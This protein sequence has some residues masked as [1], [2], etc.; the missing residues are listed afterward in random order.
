MVRFKLKHEEIFNL[1]PICA[2]YVLHTSVRLVSTSIHTP[3]IGILHILIPIE[4]GYLVFYTIRISESSNVSHITQTSIWFKMIST[5][6]ITWLLQRFFHFKILSNII[7]WFVLQFWYKSSKFF[8]FI[9]YFMNSLFYQ[10][11]IATYLQALLW[12]LSDAWIHWER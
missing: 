1:R 4:H 9:I 3:I 7:I 11:Y 10:F 8:D 12:S 5:Q 6:W 2:T